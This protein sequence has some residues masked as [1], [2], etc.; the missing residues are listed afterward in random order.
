MPCSP[1]ATSSTTPDVDTALRRCY[2]RPS[3]R[4]SPPTNRPRHNEP[5]TIRGEAQAVAFDHP[6]VGA[7]STLVAWVVEDF[8]DDAAVGGVAVAVR[9]ECPWRHRLRGGS[10]AEIA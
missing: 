9:G 1:G 8:V 2:H 6:R 5:S 7:V 4:R 10:P 3:T